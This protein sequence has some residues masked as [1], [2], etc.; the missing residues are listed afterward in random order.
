MF[1]RQLL[2]ALCLLLS[3]AACAQPSYEN[4]S[5]CNQYNPQ[6]RFA[7]ICDS[8]SPNKVR[9]VKSLPEPKALESGVLYLVEED[10]IDLTRPYLF[11]PGTGLLPADPKTPLTMEVSDSFTMPV[12]IMEFF[13]LYMPRD[14]K[15]AGLKIDGSGLTTNPAFKQALSNKQDTYLVRLK[16]SLQNDY[17]S[18]TSPV[19]LS[20]ASF[21]GSP[22]LTSIIRGEIDP[23]IATAEG[24]PFYNLSLEM[25]G[26]QNGLWL[27]NPG[28]IPAGNRGMTEPLWDVVIDGLLVYL[29]GN[30]VSEDGIRWIQ[31]AVQL[32]GVR[33]IFRQSTI[34]FSK[35][36]MDDLFRRG[37]YAE[38]VPSLIISPDNLF[39]TVDGNTNFT[40][41]F[42]Q[43]LISIKGMTSD[44]LLDANR[45]VNQSPPD[46]QLTN[47]STL[48]YFLGH[49]PVFPWLAGVQPNPAKLKAVSPMPAGSVATSADI[50]AAQCQNFTEGQFN[51]THPY[52][53]LTP[54]GEMTAQNCSDFVNIRTV[55]EWGIATNP[56]CP[57]HHQ[58]LFDQYGIPAISAGGGALVGIL[59][60]LLTVRLSA[61]RR[62]RSSYKPIN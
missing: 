19:E 39:D 32:T 23:A 31:D 26:A 10:T 45:Y 28:A 3:I 41:L 6:S 58:G 35:A 17:A 20:E 52:Q 36:I 9:P 13:L 49:N 51:E 11:P 22:N 27:E 25:N 55:Y 18:D 42:L 30:P 48:N 1:I 29:N 57:E 4:S 60:T 14:N 12:G 43:S 24:T 40:D 8:Y 54:I 53:Y 56:D 50:F 15:V 21:T 59:A 37:I 33:A 44:V 61:C 62:P 46:Y 38:N 34:T 16:A 2:T 5:Q 7:K 47:G